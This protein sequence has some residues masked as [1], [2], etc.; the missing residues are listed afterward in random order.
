MPSLG[1][2]PHSWRLR[3]R[4][5]F[6]FLSSLL[7]RNTISLQGLIPLFPFPNHSH[8]LSYLE[9]QLSATYFMSLSFVLIAS[10]ARFRAI[11][12]RF[13]VKLAPIYAALRFDTSLSPHQLGSVPDP[14]RR[15]VHVGPEESSTLLQFQSLIG[16]LP[17]KLP[18]LPEVETETSMNKKVKKKKKTSTPLVIGGEDLGGASP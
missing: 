5:H 13:L 4:S 16:P 9:L 12:H 10:L 11:L 14:F 15:E 8:P 17:P 18:Q 3:V 2:R 1:S 7:M 6:I